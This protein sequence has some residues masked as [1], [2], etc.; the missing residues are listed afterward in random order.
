MMVSI[1]EL[2]PHSVVEEHA[3]PHD[4]VGVLLEGRA[5]FIVGGEEMTL[6][7]GDCWCIPGNVRH[8]VINLESPTRAMDIFT[9]PREDWLT[10]SDAYLRAK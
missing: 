5:V 6:G 10:G 7:A 2:A 3:H 4:Q 9:P 8:K 1:V